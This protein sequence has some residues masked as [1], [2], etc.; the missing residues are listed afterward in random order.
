MIRRL[1]V[2]NYAIVR[3]L[4]IDLDSG[5]TILSGETGAGKS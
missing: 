4:D 3:D 5:L 1:K 2:K